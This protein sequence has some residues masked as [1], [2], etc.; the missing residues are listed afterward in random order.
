MTELPKPKD[1]DIKIWWIPQIPG[2]PFEVPVSSLVE[3]QK[4]LDVLADYDL[5]QLK[6]KVKP[7]FCNAGGVMVF[8][9]RYIDSESEC[10]GWV[11]FYSPDGDEF[12]E[13]TS[14]QLAQLDKLREK[15]E[16]FHGD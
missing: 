8:H 6:Q 4:I 5:F 3:A 11:D 15:G 7:D 14:D 1:G 10:D 16:P 2:K 9:T 12:K 13:L